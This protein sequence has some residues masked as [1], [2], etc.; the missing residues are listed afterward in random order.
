MRM[1]WKPRFGAGEQPLHD[2]DSRR[3]TDIRGSPKDGGSAETWYLVSLA[4]LAFQEL[5][6]RTSA[7]SPTNCFVLEFISRIG[8]KRIAS[9]SRAR[10][11]APKVSIHFSDQLLPLLHR[12]LDRRLS[13]VNSLAA[14]KATLARLHQPVLS[15]PT[16]T[17]EFSIER[18]CA[19]TASMKFA[20]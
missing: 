12:D 4:I 7:C 8:L 20:W 6:G 2:R 1:Q 3:E 10:S 19:R 5:I 9:L 16:A 17:S 15:L 11:W 14:R 18:S 13:R